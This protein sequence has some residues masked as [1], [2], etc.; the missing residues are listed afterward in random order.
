MTTG[1]HRNVAAVARTRFLFWLDAGLLIVAI[2]LETPV[3][4]GLPAHEWLGAGFG[5]SASLHLL[6]NW[7]WIAGTLRRLAAP[8]ARARI[9]LLLNATLFVVMAAAVFSGLMISEAVLPLFGLHGSPM[10]AWRK[11]HKLMSTLAVGI[12]GLHL[13][14]NWD[15][16]AGAVRTRIPRGPATSEALTQSL[17]FQGV[18]IALRRL[19]A[20]GTAFLATSA[21]FV[22]LVAWSRPV[23]TDRA[24]LRL[25]ARPEVG[26][27]ARETATVLLVVAVLALMGRKLLRIRL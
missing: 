23:P 1:E 25:W 11:I 6:L 8:G 17:G 10:L 13:A 7:Q 4:T 3:G 15:W 26:V 19:F 22:G 5:M 18:G 27:F 20:I 2:L 16:I 21:T 24:A 9:N 14:L 12:V